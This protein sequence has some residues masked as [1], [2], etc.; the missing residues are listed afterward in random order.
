MFFSVHIFAVAIKFIFVV[1]CP[2]YAVAIKFVFMM[3]T[4]VCVMSSLCSGFKFMSSLCRIVTA[5]PIKFDPKA[6]GDMFIFH[7]HILRFLYH[8][9]V[10]Y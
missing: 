10:I 8:A 9:V 1:L 2:H 6:V 3:H 5:M 7:K 4:G